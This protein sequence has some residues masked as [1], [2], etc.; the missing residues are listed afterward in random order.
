MKLETMAWLPDV[1]ERTSMGSSTQIRAVAGT[2]FLTVDSGKVK[3]GYYVRSRKDKK[4]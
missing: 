2:N 1:R 3:L 4:R